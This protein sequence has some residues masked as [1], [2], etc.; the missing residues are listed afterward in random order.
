M[1]GVA[2]QTGAGN[3]LFR[4]GMGSPD[5]D[6][7]C[8]IQIKLSPDGA[9]WMK[10]DAVA[11]CQSRGGAGTSLGEVRFSKPQ[12]IGPIKKEFDGEGGGLWEGPRR[13]PR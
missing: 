1:S 8:I 3:W 12:R 6:E 5:P 10:S 7:H 13:C 11:S 4:D 9:V 2:R